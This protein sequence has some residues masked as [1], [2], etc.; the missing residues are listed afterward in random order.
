M[1][2]Y[3]AAGLS[4]LGALPAGLLPFEII[5]AS[6]AVLTGHTLALAATLLY[7]RYVVLDVQGLIAHPAKEAPDANASAVEQ[8]AKSDAIVGADKL[9]DRHAPATLP[10]DSRSRR[11][12]AGRADDDHD[13]A[14][15]DGSEPDDGRYDEGS[16]SRQKLSKADRKRLRNERRKCA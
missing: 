9:S 7:A 10:I 8:R 13:D 11:K 5:V 4:T 1:I 6:S 16:Q 12:S 14:W 15:T 2:A 3:V